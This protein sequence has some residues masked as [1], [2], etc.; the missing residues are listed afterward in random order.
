MTIDI[1]P[2]W[3][4]VA[5]RRH[6]V[7]V[8]AHSDEGHKSAYL[9]SQTFGPVTKENRA[10]NGSKKAGSEGL[11]TFDLPVPTRSQFAAG[12]QGPKPRF[13]IRTGTSKDLTTLLYPTSL[14]ANGLPDRSRPD[15]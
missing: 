9:K 2:H 6:G 13:A 1:A 8:Q 5:A 14:P 3:L 4:V 11:I 10:H 15:Q 12:N 7:G